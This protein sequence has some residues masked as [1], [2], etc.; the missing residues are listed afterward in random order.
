MNKIFKVIWSKS[1]ECYVV[2]SE[3]ANNYSAKKAVLTSVFAVLAVTGSAAHVMGA[4]LPS[5]LT[6]KGSIKIGQYATT[7]NQS[8]IVIGTSSQFRVSSVDGYRA[9]GIGSGV[10]ASGNNILERQKIRRL[11][12]VVPPMIVVLRRQVLNLLLLVVIL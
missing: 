3:I 5:E 9:I 8:S 12:S 7:S 11:L 10:I 2:V 4:T 1:K 6:D